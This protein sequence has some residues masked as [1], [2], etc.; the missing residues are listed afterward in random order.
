M[1]TRLATALLLLAGL[2]RANE[3]GP[4]LDKMDAAAAQFKSMTAKVKSVAH[5]A[6]INEDNTDSGA[7]SVKRAKGNELRMLS[8]VLEPDPKSVAYQG[9]KLEIYYPKIQTVQEM[10][11]GKNKMVEQFFLLGFGTPRKELERDYAM[12]WIGAETLT[13]QKVTRLELTPKA[14]Q[15]LQHIKKV[16]LWINDATGFPVQQKFHQSGGDY[17]LVSY[18]EMK[19]NPDLPDSALKLKL[20]RN[21]KREMLSR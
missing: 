10:D 17:K 16:E 11:V 6:V 2:C 21:V 3:L 9:R 4:L 19:I 13:G 18:S 5:T 20:P 8:E 1:H 7:L 14:A 15:M 12:K